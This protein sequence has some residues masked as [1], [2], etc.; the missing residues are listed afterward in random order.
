ML[1]DES[2]RGRA[3]T[4]RLSDQ[5]DGWLI[6]LAGDLPSGWAVAATGGY[7]RGQLFPAGDVDAMLL[8]PRSA[9]AG[10]VESMTRQLWY[11]L[12][13]SGI[14]L[15]PAVHDDR[16]L[17]HLASTELFTVTSL[18]EMRVVTG[19]AEAVEF[20][21]QAALALWRKHPWMWLDRLVAANRERW[22]RCGDVASRL[23][24]DVKDGRGGMR[25]V[26]SL[27]WALTTARPEIERAFDAPIDDVA[28]AA[29]TIA[30]IRAET[31]R[32]TGRASN[33]LLLQDQDAV[34]AAAGY[35][36]AD[37]MMLAMS[38]EARR[39]E[40]VGE[41]FWAR[42]AEIVERR[43]RTRGR[44]HGRRRAEH[45]DR[46]LISR[47]GEVELT[48]KA[49]LGDPS[50]TFRAA[51]TAARH[52]LRLARCT[53]VQLANAPVDAD[54]VWTAEMRQA[55][56]GL[57]GAGE[58]LV[59][60]ADALEY[61]GLLSRFLPEWT[62]VRSRPQR[63]AFHIYTVD[64]HLLQTVVEAHE[65]L[66]RVSRPDLLLL[67]ALLHDIGKGFPGDH[68]EAG[69]ALVVPIA[70]RMGYDA[71]DTETLCILVDT[72][73]LL[74][75]TAT[76][77]DLDDPRTAELVADRVG[78]VD[79]LHLLR[80]LT[81]ADS[82]ATGPTG[83]TDW[84]AGLINQLTARTAACFGGERPAT[85]PDPILPV[86]VAEMVDKVRASGGVRL[87]RVS[88]A[89]VDTVAVVAADRPGLFATIAGT[90]ACH[91]IEVIGADVWTTAD[92]VAVDQIQIPRGAITDLPK[93]QRFIERTLDGALDVDERVAQRVASQSRRRRVH[94]AAPARL[95]I[96]V[97]NDESA[98]TTMVEVRS[99]D[100]EAVLYRL[101]NALH[102]FDL[103]V[104]SAK[105][106]TLGHEVVDVF[107]VRCT[108]GQLLQSDH[109]TLIA[110]LTTAISP[111]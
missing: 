21:R 3:L 17:L 52:G 104:V 53:L 98:T 6:T 24:P 40:W 64:R 70:T 46:D 92:G 83:W 19:D 9:S 88:G 25:D 42:V 76:R 86:D 36:D 69:V 13:D 35:D 23:E 93:L 90:L 51:E 87:D 106:A 72:H 4:R 5:A 15:S 14:K 22:M 100:A 38:A 97:S 18:L 20:V 67:S 32:I 73:L 91:G 1:T 109:P 7:G 29:A 54:A 61:H 11:P 34:A 94:A 85:R 110:T 107:Y 108:D 75:E 101:A 44:D 12:W 16:S 57:L 105:V 89:G 111:P 33:V 31:H 102:C 59:N 81:E 37:E 74:A 95:E 28:I 2:L 71:D 30:A 43:G 68:T 78:T 8:H 79:R 27:R 103:D 41:R 84:K 80:A 55:F 66:R 96:V 45:L 47:D 82:K 49:D 58:P 56:I 26:D 60:V 50:L 10:E 63:N 77:R 48:P 39:V 65:L 62:A 99:P